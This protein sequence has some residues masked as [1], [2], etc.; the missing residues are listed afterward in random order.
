M[1][2]V[3]K[4]YGYEIDRHPSTNYGGMEIDIEGRHSISGHPFYAEC[5]YYETEADSPRIQEF[6]GKNMARWFNNSGSLSFSVL[7]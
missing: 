1:T 3:L 6:T 4:H 5:K 2:I 7:E